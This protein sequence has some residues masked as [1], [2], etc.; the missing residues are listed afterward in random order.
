MNEIEDQPRVRLAIINEAS[1]I[2]LVLREAF[3]EHEP[4]YTSEAFIITTPTLEQILN[5]WHEGPVWIAQD[6]GQIVG[7]ISA[8]PKDQAL[9]IRSMAIQPKARG[10]GL[11]QILL[12]Q[13]ENFARQHGFKRMLLSTTPFLYRAIGLYEQFG[14]VRIDEGPHELHRTPLFTMEKPIHIDST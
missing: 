1:I 7:T 5:R 14:F 3:A 2:S 10:K 9:Y 13:V 8:V 11:G 12:E 6:A 4:L